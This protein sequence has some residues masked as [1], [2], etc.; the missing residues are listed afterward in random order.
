MKKVDFVEHVIF[1]GGCGSNGQKSCY[2]YVALSDVSALI[3]LTAR[4]KRKH[5]CDWFTLRDRETIRHSQFPLSY[6]PRHDGSI[7]AFFFFSLGVSS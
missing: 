6:K 2:T 5:H 3:F 4:Y 7:K 1:F